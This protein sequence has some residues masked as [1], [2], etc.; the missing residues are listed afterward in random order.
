MFYVN[1]QAKKKEVFHYFEA[2]HWYSSR[3]GTCF[4]SVNVTD[5]AMT[6]SDSGRIDVDLVSLQEKS[7][8]TSI[9]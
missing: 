8:S 7:I 9:F 3:I 1:I 2:S 6:A 5:A 4:P